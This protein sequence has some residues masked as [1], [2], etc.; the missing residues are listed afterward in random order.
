MRIRR[1]DAAVDIVVDVP[2]PNP[3][4]VALG[5]PDMNILYI[6]TTRRK[7]SDEELESVPTAGSLFAVKVPVKGVGEPKF[8]SGS[9]W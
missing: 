3:T 2:V 5:G 6:T 9:S 1:C 7:M 4:C 8:G